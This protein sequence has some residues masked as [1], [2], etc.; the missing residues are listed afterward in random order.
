MIYK[1]YSFSFGGTTTLK[2]DKKSMHPV[3]KTT[4]QPYNMSAGHASIT[5]ENPI[6]YNPAT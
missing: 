6:I 3:I 1:T 5:P 4:K 2:T